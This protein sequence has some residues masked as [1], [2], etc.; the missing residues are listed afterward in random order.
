VTELNNMYILNLQN[1]SGEK[2]E[3]ATPKKRED[4]RKKGQVLKSKELNS[5]LLLLAATI[6]V[7][8]LWDFEKNKMMSYMTNIFKDTVFW[9]DAEHT[10]H[11][12]RIIAQMLSVIAICIAPI[13]AILFFI[14]L[15]TNYMQVGFLFSTEAI[16]MKLSRINPLEGF[17][18]LFS[19]KSIMELFKSIFKIGVIGYVAYSYVKDKVPILIAFYDQTLEQ[20]IQAIIDIIYNVSLRASG[21]LLLLALM[22][23]F[24]QWYE[25]EKNLKMSKQD[26]K[27]E[28]KQSE[29]DP[30]LK[31]KIKEKQRQ[32]SQ[33][34]MMQD[35]PNADVVVTNPTHFAVALKYDSEK[36]EA[37][38]VI[39][40]GQDL[41]AQNIKKIAR[42]NDVPVVENKP[43]ARTLFKSIDVGESIPEALYEAVAEILAKVYKMKN[44]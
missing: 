11:V 15:I 4:A 7:R 30:Q 25:Y 16:G 31:S 6:S 38:L 24:F 19:M 20:S 32:M 42:E 35:V 12:Y 27:D 10:Q 3:K 29:G 43:L 21:V 40:K 44:N 14:A 8:F 23:Y 1:F 41:I 28:Y 17:K 34:R 18:R 5:A 39:A 22:D 26:I 9:F 13:L 33:G 2:T 37:P 36:G